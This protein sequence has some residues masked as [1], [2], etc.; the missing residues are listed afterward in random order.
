MNLPPMLK[1]FQ[2]NAIMGINSLIDTCVI[3]KP[4]I[5]HMPYNYNNGTIDSGTQLGT[6][7]ALIDFIKVNKIKYT[8]TSKYGDKLSISI[9]E[10]N[11]C[12]H[13]IEIYPY[14]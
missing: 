7:A 6:N 11:S 9:D 14:Y 8:I 13:A 2:T 4:S 1:K 10:Y 3:L 5:Q 12:I